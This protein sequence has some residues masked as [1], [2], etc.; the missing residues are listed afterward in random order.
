[1]LF[2]FLLY[3]IVD[4]CG[5][6]G[7]VIARFNATFLL[8]LCRDFDRLSKENPEENNE[9]V[10]SEINLNDIDSECISC[11]RSEEFRWGVNKSRCVDKKQIFTVTSVKWEYN[12]IARVIKKP[13]K[14]FI[15]VERAYA[16]N[17]LLDLLLSLEQRNFSIIWCLNW[18]NRCL[19]KQAF[20]LAVVC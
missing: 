20:C 17:S 13:S 12:Q 15:E 5:M 3:F 10:G 19:W 8:S 16:N 11:N 2:A 4:L 18:Q 6:C 7:F 1:M 9:L 14:S